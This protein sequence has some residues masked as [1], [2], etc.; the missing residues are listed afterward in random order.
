MVKNESDKNEHSTRSNKKATQVIR[1][2]H[3]IL[4]LKS[5]EIMSILRGHELKKGHSGIVSM[6]GGF[7]VFGFV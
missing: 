6:L 7:Y 1:F 5:M 3:V 4:M 2:G